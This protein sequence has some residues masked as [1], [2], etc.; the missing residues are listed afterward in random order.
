MKGHAK[1]KYKYRKRKCVPEP[2]TDFS[3]HLKESNKNVLS[4]LEKDE[5]WRASTKAGDFPDQAPEDSQKMIQTLIKVMTRTSCAVAH[6]SQC[7]ININN[8]Y[9]LSY[10]KI[11]YPACLD[12]AI[13]KELRFAY[14]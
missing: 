9:S 5:E 4:P 14:R 8:I 12:I 7:L 2:K 11:C 10:V 6:T 13:G 1:G 3:R